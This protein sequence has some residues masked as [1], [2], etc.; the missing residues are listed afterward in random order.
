MVQGRA[1]R[2]LLVAGHV[3]VDHYLTV[4]SIPGEDRTVPILAER[5]ELGGT[6][7]NVARAAAR[8]GVGVGILSRV[9][10]GFP[11]AFRSVLA[12]EG[13]DLRGLVRVRGLPTPTC[14]ILEQPD[15]RTRMLIQQGPMSSAANASVP[16]A[17]SRSYR[18][19]HLGT[20]DPRY[21]LRLAR[22]ARRARQHVA[23]DPAQE[24]F[25]RWDR[26]TFQAILPLTDLLFGNR[27]EVARAAAWVG[28]G[29]PTRLLERVPLVVRTEGIHGATAFFRGGTAHAAGRRPR[30]VR[31]LVG[32]GDAFRGGFY[33][34]WLAGEPLSQCLDAGNREAL[35]RIEGVS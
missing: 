11:P 22:E 33:G 20:G 29:G 15:G 24:I 17:W 4:A 26:P 8:H 31:T 30:H 19:L 6:A 25:Y 28:G 27:A 14:T 7:T 2:E 16:G 34:A 13:I 3:V 1:R 32:A 23:L 10:D 9:G 21:Y 12:S 35:A 5:A 18:W